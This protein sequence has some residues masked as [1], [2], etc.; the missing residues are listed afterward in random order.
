MNNRRPPWDGSDSRRDISGLDGEVNFPVVPA[1]G[2]ELAPLPEVKDLLA[3]RLLGLTLEE[4]KEI[5]AVCVNLESLSSRLVPALE[6]R[7]DVRLA[8]G[9]EE[10]RHPIFLRHDL[11][12]DRAR[13]DHSRPAH[14]AGDAEAAF[15]GGTLLPVEWCGSPIRPAHDLSTVVGAVNDNRVVSKFQVINLLEQFTHHIV[16]LDHAV[17]CETDARPPVRL[18]LEVGPDV[19]PGGVEPDEEWPV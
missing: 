2:V 13:F 16:V 11:V 14:Q 17:G 18:L 4:G 12:D 1:D 3:G 10:G 7:D 8:R 19:H 6:L 9:G 15:P 5:E